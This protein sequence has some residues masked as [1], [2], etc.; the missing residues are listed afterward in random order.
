MRSVDR[1]LGHAHGARSWKIR[2]E[3]LL[4]VL[5]ALAALPP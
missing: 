5:L 2:S 1:N 4:W 3:S